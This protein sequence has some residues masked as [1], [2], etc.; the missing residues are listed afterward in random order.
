MGWTGRTVV[1][2]YLQFV[3]FYFTPTLYGKPQPATKRDVQNCMSNAPCSSKFILFR[4]LGQ[5]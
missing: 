1:S 5:L 3:V 4:K 2:A